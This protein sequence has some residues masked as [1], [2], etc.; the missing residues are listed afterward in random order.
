MTYHLA[1][2]I[3][4]SSGRLVLG[5]LEENLMKTEEIHRFP[6]GMVERN[7]HLCWN[8]DSLFDEI[9][10][11]MK[12]CAGS[13]KTPTSVGIDTWGVDFVLLDD[14]GNVLGDTIAYRDSR[15][16]G[17]DKIIYGII[18]EAELYKRTG[19]QP[20]LFN[21]IFQLVALKR[22]NPELITRASRFMMI[23][24]Y[25]HYR[26]SGAAV[27]EYTNATSTG[28]VNVH[29]NKW[30]REIIN[31][32]GLPEGI[33]YDFI[34]P[35][36]TIGRLTPEVRRLTGYDC[37]VLAPSTHDTASAVVA[38]SDDS[39]YISSGTWSLMGI[40]TET[41]NCSTDSRLAGFT[42][43]GGY[44]GVIR[45]LVTIMGMWMI[46]SIS[47][48]L[49]NKYSFAELNDLAQK[50]EIKSVVDCNDNRF[51]APESMIDEIKA[52][53]KETGQD[54]PSTPGELA[55]VAYQSL[56][57][58]YAKAAADLEK[59]TGRIYNTIHIIGGGSNASCLNQL[60]A[61]STGKTVIS[62][63]SEATAIGNLAVQM[64]SSGELDNLTKARECIKDSFP[65]NIYNP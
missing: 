49:G 47:K 9:L 43:E 58:F 57:G 22:E 19:T 7:G 2:D 55:A 37:T 60:T 3:G 30:D 64:I 35:G 8:L 15:T 4:A 52:F 34:K 31:Q 28:L 18:P 42:N 54:V 51:Y 26:L 65:V 13:G 39:I 17:I 12:K 10:A 44:N 59:L 40:E 6:N 46:Q 16:N 53:C 33:F 45:Y 56:A 21:T 27:N 29:T 41:P 5:R 1:I 36:T 24:D 61:K 14:G 11:G 48:E 23:P 62:G 20:Q 25:L 38:A 63:P 32:L 50:A